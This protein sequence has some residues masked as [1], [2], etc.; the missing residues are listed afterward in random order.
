MLLTEYRCLRFIN[1]PIL[2]QQRSDGTTNLTLS[3]PLRHNKND[4]LGKSLPVC[5]KDVTGW[6]T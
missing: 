5:L 4:V 6:Y 2:E 3:L 1:K